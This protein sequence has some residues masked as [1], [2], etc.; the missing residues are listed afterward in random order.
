[1]TPP[2]S[3]FGASPSRGRHWWPGEAGS[4]VARAWNP[5]AYVR[6]RLQRFW[7]SRLTPKDSTTLTQHNIYILPTRAGFML[8][9]TLLIL[10]WS[11]ASTTSSIWAIC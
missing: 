3:A 7:M 10:C 4:T 2:R 11:P 9:I 1:M 6:A 5:F 8:A